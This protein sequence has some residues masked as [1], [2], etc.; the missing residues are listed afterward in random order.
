MAILQVG[1]RDDVLI[2][3][4]WSMPIV[5]EK[6]TKG[7]PS[8]SVALKRVCEDLPIMTIGP[9][10]CAVLFWLIA[11][12]MSSFMEW[13]KS[14]FLKLQKPWIKRSYQNDCLLS[15]GFV[16][17]LIQC[18]RRPSNVLPMRRYPLTKLCLL[19]RSKCNLMNKIH[20]MEK[21]WHRAMA[22]AMLCKIALPCH[23]HRKKWTMCIAC[24]I[25]ESGI[26]CMMPQVVCL[27]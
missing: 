24:H 6:L 22:I 15:K 1:N 23:W 11:K 25:Q 13:E 16:T 12:Q 2:V 9:I 26:L 17:L 3:L 14:K 5:C 19:K 4:R 7:C 18:Q 20:I 10:R 21:M 8:L 27:P